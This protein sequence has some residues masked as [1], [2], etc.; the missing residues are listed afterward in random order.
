MTNNAKS[1]KTLR[2]VKMAMLVALSVV[3]VV[4]IHF[5]IFPSAAF[6]EYDPA[7]IPIFIGTFAFGPTAGV[8]IT[9]LVSVNQGTSVC[10]A[11]QI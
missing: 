5:P 11:G 1:K 2:L 3:L 6:L 4:L 8:I 9:I 10:A 7:A